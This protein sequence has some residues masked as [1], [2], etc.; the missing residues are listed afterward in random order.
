MRP[1]CSGTTGSAGAPAGNASAVKH[2]MR[3]QHG[4]TL[5]VVT[6]DARIA[7]QADRKIQLN[8]GRIVG[9]AV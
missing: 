5:V 6:H 7:D 3:A 4:S 9:Q 1:S 2:S 8:G